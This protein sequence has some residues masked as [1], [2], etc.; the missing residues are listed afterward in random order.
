MLKLFALIISLMS[1]SAIGNPPQSKVYV[2]SHKNTILINT[3]INRNSYVSFSKA[4]HNMSS[5]QVLIYIDS[6]GGSVID[7]A[8]LI[9]LANSVKKSKGL[10]YTCLI[11]NAASMAFAIAQSICDHRVVSPTSILMQHQ[12]A[13][14]TG[15]QIERISSLV[16]MVKDLEAYLNRVQA[17]RLGISVKRFRALITND[18]Y[19]VGSN[20]ISAKAADSVGFWFCATKKRCPLL[21]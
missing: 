2:M 21:Y 17:K 14:S 6:L 10:V 8:M 20:A 19:L 18:W 5:N 9:H 7:G 12:M 16:K 4:L 13:F 11:Q 3:E 1:F 15:G